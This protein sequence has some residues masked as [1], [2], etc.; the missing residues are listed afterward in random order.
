MS[1]VLVSEVAVKSLLVS[2]IP[3][4]KLSGSGVERKDGAALFW[5]VHNGLN[6]IGLD[7]REIVPNSSC[8]I[9]IVQRRS[10]PFLDPGYLCWLNCR[11]V[12]RRRPQF[13]NRGHAQSIGG[14]HSPRQTPY[15]RSAHF[16]TAFKCH[17][18]AIADVSERRHTAKASPLAFSLLT[19]K[20]K[21]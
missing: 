14:A 8:R 9:A 12:W 7:Q 10:N 3:T 21:A 2:R 11:N 15:W 6:R 19:K 17:T 5:M 4:F 13:L 1:R 16:T 20:E 18:C